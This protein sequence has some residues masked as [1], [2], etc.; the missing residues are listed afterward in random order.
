MQ[1]FA[2]SLV[3][4]RKSGDTGINLSQLV[5]SDREGKVTKTSSRTLRKLPSRRERKKRKKRENICRD[6]FHVRV[7]GGDEITFITKE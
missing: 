4:A 5:R 1:F 7:E 2:F 3:K 6:I